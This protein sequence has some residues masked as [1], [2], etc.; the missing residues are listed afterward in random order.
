MG[1]FR[2]V[3]RFFSEAADNFTAFFLSILIALFV[4][5]AGGW[6][7]RVLFGSETTSQYLKRY[8]DFY[9]HPDETALGQWAKG[10]LSRVRR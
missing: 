9:H 2:G 8:A 3:C 5:F 7:V 10:A 4:L 1:F 6:A